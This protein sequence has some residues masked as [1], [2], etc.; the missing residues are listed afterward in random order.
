M[1]WLGQGHVILLSE[2]LAR[3]NETS[4]NSMSPESCPWLPHPGWVV[5]LLP[6]AGYFLVSQRPSVGG[7]A[8][9][10]R[11]SMRDRKNQPEVSCET[12][13]VRNVGVVVRRMKMGEW[14]S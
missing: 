8:R 10:S 2:P 4:S 1:A 3:L 13:G 12:G 7:G 9:V 5:S 6:E 11:V 14:V